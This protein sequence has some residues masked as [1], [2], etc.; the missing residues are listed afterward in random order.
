MA[1]AGVLE[2]L[3]TLKAA[4]LSNP[5]RVTEVVIDLLGTPNQQSTRC[6]RYGSLVGGPGRSLQVWTNGMW[7]D[8][9]PTGTPILDWKGNPRISGDLIHLTAAKLNLPFQETANLLAS[10]F[11]VPEVYQQKGSEE[12]VP[13]K[14]VVHGFEEMGL[15]PATENS[16]AMV[17]LNKRGLSPG[18]L[19]LYRLHQG[20]VIREG[21]DHICAVL[22]YLSRDGTRLLNA[23]YRGVEE[24]I[25][26]CFP[27]SPPV[28]FGL[29]L[30]NP[31]DKRLVLCEAEID[32]VSVKEAC[33]SINVVAFGGAG[34][35]K[36]VIEYMRKYLDT[37]ETFIIAFDKDPAGEQGEKDVIECLGMRRCKRVVLIGG[38]DCNEV[39]VKRGPEVLADAIENAEQVV[40]STMVNLVKATETLID[41]YYGPLF[42]EAY[43]PDE[44]GYQ[45]RLLPWELCLWAGETGTGKSTV[46]RQIISKCVIS[47]DERALFI[48]SEDSAADYLS[49]LCWMLKGQ[50]PEPDDIRKF[51]AWCHDTKRIL[52][53]DLT[54][55]TGKRVLNIHEVVK[56]VEQFV[57][58]FGVKYVVLDNVTFLVS[59]ADYVKGREAATEL[60]ALPQRLG[61]SFHVVAHGATRALGMMGRESRALKAHEIRGVQELPMGS[62]N[63]ISVYRNFEEEV[64]SE[65]SSR[66]VLYYALVKARR[67]SDD[68]ERGSLRSV[69]RWTF[70][71]KAKQFTSDRAGRPINYIRKYEIDS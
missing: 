41:R 65:D 3:A 56:Q 19:K 44:L 63:I 64:Q 60:V 18:V 35:V 29:H 14:V 24:K 48:T 17:Y 36:G 4:I 1:D 58:T 9:N 57:D 70:F 38:K 13:F 12:A 71:P 23:K 32:A 54:D 42:A 26:D 33:P 52:I 61:V 68:S 67:A 49:D 11:N 53:T 55:R 27:Q 16:K 31:S 34:R 69:G 46:I 5:A 50:R 66:S 10:K 2:R 39:L 20:S 43:Q 51:S 7:R 15:H 37:F 8:A 22:P 30:I 25:F 59:A 47:R 28:A 62:Q 21:K 40:P 6:L 45:L